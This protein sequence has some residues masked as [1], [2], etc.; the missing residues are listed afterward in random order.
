M[1]IQDLTTEGLSLLRFLG[2]PLSEFSGSAL[3]FHRAQLQKT[4]VDQMVGQLHLSHRLVS[5]DESDTEVSLEFSNGH[6]ATCDLL[7]AMDGINSV[8]RKIFS[9]RQGAP[10]H[11]V[12][13]GDIA[14]RALIPT[15]KLQSRFPGHRAMKVPIMVW[16]YSQYDAQFYRTDIFI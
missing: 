13:S 12:W 14:Y 11:L 15:G 7:I 9:D 16:K 5:Y 6:K 4:I 2:F 1:H 3:R 10:A 8:S